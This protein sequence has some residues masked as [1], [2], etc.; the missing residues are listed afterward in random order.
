MKPDKLTRVPRDEKKVIAGQLLMNQRHCQ[1]SASD[2][3]ER[4]DSLRRFFK[5]SVFA[6]EIF[7]FLNQLRQGNSQAM[8]QRVGQVQTRVSDKS[9]DPADHF[10]V[11]IGKLAQLFL[12]QLFGPSLVAKHNAER[13]AQISSDHDGILPV[14]KTNKTGTI[15]GVFVLALNSGKPI[16]QKT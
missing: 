2:Q 6:S 13:F 5:G 16:I 11:N 12:S 10:N 14:S 15:G 7:R 9:F 3:S 1:F 8:R 4:L